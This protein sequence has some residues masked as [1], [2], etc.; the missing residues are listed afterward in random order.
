MIRVGTFTPSVLLRVARRTGRLGEPVE[1]VPVASSPAQFAALADGSLDAGLTSPDNV[2]G[3]RGRVDVR[4]LAAIDRGMGLG[5]YSRLPAGQLSGSRFGVDV[6][7]SGFA[8][9]MY[10]ILDDLG[11]T[12]RNLVTLGSTP[13]RLR[14][15]LAGECDATMLNA[16]N[17]LVASAAGLSLIGSAPQPYLGTVLVALSDMSDLSRALIGTADA[18]LAGSYHDLVVEEA[19]TAL[20]LPDDLARRYLERLL[21]PTDGL[22]A[23]GKVDPAA[24]ATVEDLRRKYGR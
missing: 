7:T 4:V 13:K 11:I 9:A 18:I 3:H 12:E 15:L 20:H 19:S 24:M 6:P 5:L 8:F 1:E 14:A 2:L 21:S 16:G 22:V 17:E 23:G 10:A